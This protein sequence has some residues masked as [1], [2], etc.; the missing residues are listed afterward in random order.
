VALLVTISAAW[1]LIS[2]VLQIKNL[3]VDQ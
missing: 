3:R 2:P 1:G